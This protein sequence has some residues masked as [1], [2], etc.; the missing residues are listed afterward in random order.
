ML[1]AIKKE[2]E[3]RQ[4]RESVH[5]ELNNHFAYK[6]LYNY[7][8]IVIKTRNYVYLLFLLK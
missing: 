4:G 6:K 7:E 2:G 5:L 8:T 3:E 1:N